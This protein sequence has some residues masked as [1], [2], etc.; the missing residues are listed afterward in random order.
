[1]SL[2]IKLKNLSNQNED[3]VSK[4]LKKRQSLPVILTIVLAIS[5]FLYSLFNSYTVYDETLTK[6]IRVEQRIEKYNNLIKDIDAQ[7][8]LKESDIKNIQSMSVDSK[9]PIS[10]LTKVCELLKKRE[11]IGSFYII[12][13][14]N[15]EYTNV[16]DIEIQ[17][18]YGDKSL[19][20]LV[21]KIVLDKVYYLKEIEQTKKGF[22]AQIFNPAS[23]D[24]K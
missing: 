3:W 13:R 2:F 12:K 18:S 15:K 11:V 21:S 17:V 22:K 4:T 19:L 20:Y 7:I 6:K 16:L 23:E 1:M 9:G 24:I 8:K 10:L 14:Q 5:F